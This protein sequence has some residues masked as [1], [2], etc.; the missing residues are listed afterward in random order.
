[1]RNAVYYFAIVTL[2]VGFASCNGTGTS[3]TTDT[4]TNSNMQMNPGDSAVTT[5]TTTT[6]THHRYTGT[7]VPQPTAKYYDLKS[8]KQITV[9]VDTVRGSV[10]NAE[11]NEPVDLFVDQTKHDTIYGQTGTVVNNYIIRDQ[12]DYRVDTVRINSGETAAPAPEPTTTTEP[13]DKMKSKSK[14]DKDKVKTKNK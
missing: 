10:V 4:V 7:F 1:M 2:S 6:V 12:G 11:T 14:G 5:T 13:A 8:H 3:T 9:R